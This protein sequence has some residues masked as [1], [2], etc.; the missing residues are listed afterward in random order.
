M[1]NERCY[2]FKGSYLSHTMKNQ[3]EPE[4]TFWQFE[5]SPISIVDVN[6]AIAIAETRSWLAC[7]CIAFTAN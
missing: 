3:F 1:F 5:R 7:S 2:G 6:S 4:L